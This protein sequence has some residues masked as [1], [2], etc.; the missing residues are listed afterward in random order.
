MVLPSNL[1]DFRISCIFSPHVAHFAEFYPSM[2]MT[3][4]ATPILPR[5]AFV[6]AGLSAV[7]AGSAVSLAIFGGMSKVRAS[8]FQFSRGTSLA[9]GEEARLRGLLAQALADERIHVTVLGHTGDAGDPAAN[10]AL[11]DERAAVVHAMALAAG[12][13]P[14]R[15]TLKGVG[16]A[17]PLPQVDGESDRAYQSRLARVEVA[18]QLRK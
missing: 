12:I 11:S 4:R 17:A 5:R 14:D 15:I 13:E 8:S 2:R 1:L 7:L 9:T 18:L 3:Q 16:G 10:L 6:A